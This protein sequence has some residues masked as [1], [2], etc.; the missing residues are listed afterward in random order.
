MIT[1]NDIALDALDDSN[2][3]GPSLK[4]KTKRDPGTE[5]TGIVDAPRCF[6]VGERSHGDHRELDCL[7]A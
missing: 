2:N 4:S 6:W 3:T 7:G 1:G 5:A